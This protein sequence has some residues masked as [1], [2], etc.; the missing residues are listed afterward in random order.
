MLK[1]RPNRRKGCQIH[2]TENVLQSIFYNYLFSIHQKTSLELLT[3]RCK[4]YFHNS[5]KM[6]TGADASQTDLLTL[7]VFYGELIDFQ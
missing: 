6:F 5:D 1:I 4:P 2:L 7:L 3:A